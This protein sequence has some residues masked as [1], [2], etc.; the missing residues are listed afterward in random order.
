MRKL[1]EA[2]RAEAP[3]S[4]HTWRQMVELVRN[5]ICA[6]SWHVGDEESEAMWKPI[7]FVH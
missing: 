2:G 1:R 3:D 7:S 4:L 6:S 5:T